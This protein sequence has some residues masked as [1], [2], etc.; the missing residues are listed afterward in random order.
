MRAYKAA[1]IFATL[2]TA[3][4][5]GCGGTRASTDAG[6]VMPSE[7]GGTDDA[8][9]E[10]STSDGPEGSLDATVTLDG[11]CGP[12]TCPQGCCGSSGSCYVQPD[13][14][15][16]GSHGA[17]C[18]ICDAPF[19]CRNGVCVYE[20]PGCNSETCSPGCCVDANTCASGLNALACGSDGAQCAKCLT[21]QACNEQVKGGGACGP[22]PGPGC[23]PSN[24][25]GC[26]LP[27]AQGDVCADG[28]QDFACGRGGAGCTI[29]SPSLTCQPSGVCR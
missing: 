12:S 4:P 2:I 25:A 18:A 17:A 3:S 26:C 24:C 23:G 20:Q 5:L 8:L 6:P 19:G 11:P 7:G 21:G 27:L 28:N 9:A 1:G 22:P 13:D 16:C 15:N 29:C 14:F 10:D